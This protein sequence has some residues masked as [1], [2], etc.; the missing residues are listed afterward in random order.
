MNQG[1]YAQAKDFFVKARAGFEST[2]NRS[3]VGGILTSLGILSE[4]QHEYEAALAYYEQALTIKQALN[5]RAE[6]A[7][8]FV[9]IGCRSS[10]WSKGVHRRG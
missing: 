3:G 6:V 10:P 4:L 1:N 8:L 2:K 5:E 9:N 7:G